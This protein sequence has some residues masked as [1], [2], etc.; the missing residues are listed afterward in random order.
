V[1][2]DP[3][4]FR[5]VIGHFAT[6]VTVITTAAGDE[7]QGMTANAVASLSLDPV[8]VLICVD[9]ETHTHRVLEQGRV[10]AVNILGEHQ[11]DVSR[12]FAKRAE[13]ELGT[14]RGQRFRRGVTGAPVLEDCLAFLECRVASFH[15]GGDHS[16]VLGEVVD[17]G[18]V[19]DVPPLLFFRGKYGRLAPLAE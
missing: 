7:L 15:G 10:F 4:E 5:N 18:I 9:K 1:S 2:I 8:M 16:V 14:L 12:I 17:Q 3:I 19:R 13:P 11:E 6:G